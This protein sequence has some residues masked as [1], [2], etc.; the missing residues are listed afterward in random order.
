MKK[1]LKVTLG[2]EFDTGPELAV[3]EIS[4]ALAA[5]ILE[6][7]EY[8]KKIGADTISFVDDTP[9]FFVRDYESEDEYAFRESLDPDDC[10]TEC[11][12]L[13]VNAY[14]LYW[15]GTQKCYLGRFETETIPLSEL[16]SECMGRKAA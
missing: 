16:E 12:K 3:V 2:N 14:D 4:S 5:R 1:V 7:S 15:S 13:N 10:S 11:V 9:D 6:I 8:V